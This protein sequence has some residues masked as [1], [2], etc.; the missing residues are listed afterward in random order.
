MEFFNNEC[1]ACGGATIRDGNEFVC[2]FCGSKWAMIA[3]DSLQVQLQNAW[4]ALRQSDFDK[5]VELFEDIIVGDSK[6]YEAHWG[7]ALAQN[8]I[9][10]VNDLNEHKKVPTCNNITENVFTENK[11]VKKA[12]SL[13]PAKISDDYKIQAEKIEKIRKEW[14]EKASKEPPYDVFICFKDS[15]KENNIERTS[16]SVNAQEL[17][18]YLVSQ[19]Y[20]VF[21]SRVS[22]R[23]KLAEQYEPYIYNA[24]KTAKVMVVYGEKA[25]YFN[26]VWLKNEWNRF[27][28]RIERGEKHKN[29]LVVAY[30]NVDI[31]DLPA[32]LR[33]RQCIDASEM[34]FLSA[35]DNHIKKVIELSTQNIHLDRIKVESGQMSKRASRLAVNS[36]KTREIGTGIAAVTDIDEAQRLSLINKYLNLESWNDADKLI[37]KVLFDNPSSAEALWYSI[38]STNRAKNDESLRIAL[39]N[40]AFKKIDYVER[41]LQCSSKDFASRILDLL[42]GIN[43]A[44]DALYVDILKRILPY[45][46]LRRDEKIKNAFEYA[47]SKKYTNSFDLLILTLETHDVDRY[48]EY[49]F[50]FARVLDDSDLKIKYLNSIIS[51]DEGNVDA[52]KMKLQI[53]FLRNTD[54]K[55]LIDDLEALLKYSKSPDDEI[56]SVFEAFSSSFGVIT[57]NTVRFSKQ[58]IRYYSGEILNIKSTLLAFAD[59]LLKSKYMNDAKY[60]YTLTISVDKKCADAFWGMCLA[61]IGASSESD[62]LNC[63]LLIK[64]CSEFEKY[65]TLVDDDR[66]G[67]CI[68][69]SQMQE[70]AI[71]DKKTS[72]KNEKESIKNNIE[73]AKEEIKKERRLYKTRS[74]SFKVG[75][76]CSIFSIL[77]LIGALFTFI[78]IFIN[79]TNITKNFDVNNV[80]ELIQAV[81][82]K[83]IIL[84]L[85]FWVAYAIFAAITIHCLYRWN[86]FGALVFSFFIIPVA[87]GFMIYSISKTI[88]QL[89]KLSESRNAR[90]KELKQRIKQENQN[91][92]MFERGRV[93]SYK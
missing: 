50:R 54:V 88:S 30:K 69:L 81:S 49:N 66:Q 40:H 17:Y 8:G 45:S 12:V 46:Y 11:D 55:I 3:E 70:K 4:E 84:I 16:D 79:I 9:V 87:L 52:Y 27:R 34:T 68:K 78:Y 26:A 92:D 7:K 90:I 15:D 62:I 91:Y 82:D 73:M 64:D 32:G 28:T 47:I 42:Y 51:V 25:E 93:A 74:R 37:D 75:R 5:S 36:V 86:W 39:Q 29:S 18:T 56:I 65:L 53:N 13:A 48:I 19:G 2:K 41:L 22:L 61:T 85:F 21:F 33:S 1:R 24:L 63:T 14:L 89:K 60:Y 59:K 23:D 67:Y 35:L 83:K 80:D 31:S 10:F 76:T 71:S 44:E 77:S 6:N 72:L 57:D 20:N 58:L 43:A 38:L